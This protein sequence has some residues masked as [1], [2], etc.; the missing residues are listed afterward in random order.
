MA[1]RSEQTAESSEG[2][3]LLRLFRGRLSSS[4]LC[5][6]C[7][8]LSTRVE[9]IQ[10][11]ELEIG[12]AATLQEALSQFCASEA[13]GPEGG[14]PYACDSCCA[15]TR[16]EKYLRLQEAPRVLRIQVLYKCRVR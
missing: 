2:N 5:A 1:A 9:G 15:L 12:R 13:L 4:V 10:G 3:Y 16:A 7:G 11:L 8:G 14:N 6:Q